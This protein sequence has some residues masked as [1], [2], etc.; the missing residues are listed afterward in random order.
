MIYSYK[1]WGNLLH[2]SRV[3]DDQVTRVL[4]VKILIGAVIKKE[5]WLPQQGGVNSDVLNMGYFSE[6]KMIKE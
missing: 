5:V 4:G 2:I 1:T 6:K 3:V